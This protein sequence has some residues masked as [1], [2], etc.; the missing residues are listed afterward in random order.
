MATKKR[1]KKR[2]LIILGAGSSLELGMPSVAQIDSEMKAWSA[3][4]SNTRAA[5]DIFLALWDSIQTYY[6][7]ELKPLLRPI[8]NYEKVLGEMV[9]L[10]A[11]MRPAPHGTTF[12]Q[13]IGYDHIPLPEWAG[14]NTYGPHA[15]IN[16]ALTHLLIKLA[17]H[18][19]LKSLRFLPPGAEFLRYQTIFN[20]LGREFELG[21]Y[22]LNHDAAAV[23]ALPKAFTGFDANGRFDPTEVHTRRNWG[24]LYHLH[25]CVYHSLDPA[26]PG[27]P[28][29]WVA[30]LTKHHNYGYAVSS[31]QEQTQN[32]SFPRTVLL[33]GGYK[34]DQLLN[35]PFQSLY[36]SLV[37]HVYQADAIMLGG[38]GFGDIHVNRALEKR[39]NST[40]HRPP[41]AV[42]D[43]SDPKRGDPMEFRHDPWSQTLCE[44][45]SVRP[46]SFREPGH[47]APPVIGDLIGGKQMEVAESERVAIWHGGFL[48]IADA[49]PML[50]SHLQS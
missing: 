24:I 50:C 17:E 47:T 1:K 34:L 13:F 38:Y 4:F 3:A 27:S 44:T 21:I 35:E 49:L 46:T 20:E 37:R 18:F 36:A 15:T 6:D 16:L 31:A 33:A 42:I 48:G 14:D 43:Y 28:I 10:A 40:A 9:E 29:R 32:K 22:N 11:W 26:D 39:I 5:T 30:P 12:R 25:G 7:R 23:T 41:I 45:F 19:R 8:V 2:L